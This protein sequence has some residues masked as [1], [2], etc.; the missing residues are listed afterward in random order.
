MAWGFVANKKNTL[1][2]TIGIVGIENCFN[3]KKQ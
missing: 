1:T 2:G 3:Q